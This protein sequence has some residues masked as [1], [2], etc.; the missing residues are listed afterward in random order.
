M[1]SYFSF[2][3]LTISIQ[4]LAGLPRL[5]YAKEK[6]GAAEQLRLYILYYYE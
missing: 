6:A 5:S 1:H 4:W 2:H 3:P